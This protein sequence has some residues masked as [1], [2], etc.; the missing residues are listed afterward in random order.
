[1]APLTIPAWTTATAG[2][3]T[4][5]DPLAPGTDSWTVRP[6]RDREWSSSTRHRCTCRRSAAK[7]GSECRTS[8]L[9]WLA[10]A[11]PSKFRV[12]AL[13]INA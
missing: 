9:W 2:S 12:S 7:I 1:M 11:R 8:A 13:V 4:P 3:M 10:T 5:L 6:R